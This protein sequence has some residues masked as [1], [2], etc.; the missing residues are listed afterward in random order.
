MP[1]FLLTLFGPQGQYRR[2]ASLFLWGL[3]AV[4]LLAA[5]A[6]SGAFARDLKRLPWHLMD[7]RYDLTQPQPFSSLAVTLDVKA[8]PSEGDYFYLCALWGHIGENSFYLGLQTDVHNGLVRQFDGPGLIFTRWGSGDPADSRPAS[9]GWVVPPN[10]NTPDEGLSI[11]VRRPLNWTDGRYTFVL[12]K[13]PANPLTLSTWI[14]LLV[15]DHQ[16]GRWID[17]G[18][19]R[20]PTRTPVL[21][22][23][24]VTFAELYGKNRTMFPTPQDQARGFDPITLTIHPLIIDG[25]AVRPVGRVVQP[26]NVP[27]RITE[28]NQMVPDGQGVT[29]NIRPD[30]PTD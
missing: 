8:T 7:Y 2:R 15:F 29:I 9:D 12:Q 30:G 4:A 17:G 3:L 22:R 23:N 19:L 28:Q 10:P 14:D 18:G 21:S 26:R 1:G 6:T 20:F 16:T 5:T 13:R 24:P 25:K 27:G 11:S